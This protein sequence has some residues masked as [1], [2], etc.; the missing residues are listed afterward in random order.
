MNEEI[1]NFKNTI[2]KD[3]HQYL[4]KK[5]MVDERLAECPDVDNCYKEILAHYLEDG[6]QEYEKYPTASLGWMMYIGMALAEMWD[7][8]WSRYSKE[9][10]LYK[11]MR[12]QRGYDHLDEYISEKILNLD[13]RLA[14][15][16][17]L[18][19]CDCATRLNSALMH[20]SFE[21]GT[22]DAFFAYVSCLDVLFEMGVSVQLKALGYKMTLYGNC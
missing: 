21:R 16:L 7:K 12:D 1:V 13:I 8:D 3:L 11:W 10:N 4:K 22:E 6:V 5:G 2:R 17:S 14:D 18:S 19:I 20:S 9:K 15:A